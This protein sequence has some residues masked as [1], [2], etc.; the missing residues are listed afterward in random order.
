MISQ[1]K[2]KHLSEH[3]TSSTAVAPHLFKSPPQACESRQAEIQRDDRC[4]T[5]ASDVKY[6]D[7]TRANMDNIHAAVGHARKR[8]EGYPLGSQASDTP[9]DATCPSGTVSIEGD[10]SCCASWHRCAMR[11]KNPS[12]CWGTCGYLVASNSAVPSVC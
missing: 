9:W 8:Y 12:V 4:T 5:C 3:S 10:Q 7:S 11:D 2:Y 6:I 1:I